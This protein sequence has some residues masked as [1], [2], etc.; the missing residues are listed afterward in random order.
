MEVQV[1]K[2]VEGEFKQNK[3]RG[4]EEDAI[5]PRRKGCIGRKR[6]DDMEAR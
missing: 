4:K 3:L 1:L 5:H 2:L 6:N